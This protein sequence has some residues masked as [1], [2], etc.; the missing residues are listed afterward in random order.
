MGAFALLLWYRT[1]KKDI[2]WKLISGTTH[3]KVSVN[4][5]T[6]HMCLQMY[7]TRFKFMCLFLL[8]NINE[9][10]PPP[11]PLFSVVMGYAAAS[12]LILYCECT[13]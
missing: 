12:L 7:A 10:R 9:I 1:Y 6:T 11:P 13:P 4:P 2:Q 5:F 8:A 3:L